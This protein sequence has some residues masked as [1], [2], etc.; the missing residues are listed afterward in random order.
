MLKGLNYNKIILIYS[1]LI[2]ILLGYIFYN[3]YNKRSENNII[4]NYITSVSNYKQ[5]DDKTLGILEIPKINIQKSLYDMNSKNNT[6]S[7][8]LQILKKSTMPDHENSILAIAAHSG[9]GSKAFFKNLY[10]LDSNDEIKLYFQDNIYFY[11]V[12]A[13]YEVNK[14]GTISI[15]NSTKKQLVLTTCSQTDKTKQIVVLANLKY[16]KKITA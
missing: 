13:N 2:I 14:N 12:T 3:Y 9:N 11:Y 16:Q 15:P 1:L 10:K 6:I 5:E 4:N 7:K 8:N